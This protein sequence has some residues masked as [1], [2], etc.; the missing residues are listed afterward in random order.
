MERTV[1]RRLRMAGFGGLE[2]ALGRKAKKSQTDAMRNLSSRGAEVVWEDKDPGAPPPKP[3][4]QKKVGDYASLLI[5]LGAAGALAAFMMNRNATATTG[6]TCPT[7]R[8]PSGTVIQ[9]R[10]I[11]GECVWPDWVECLDDTDCNKGDVCSDGVCE[12]GY[13]SVHDPYS[14]YQVFNPG[15]SIR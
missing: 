14:P 4:K 3:T 9:S 10:E 15:I 13:P 11:D 1:W 8:F 7:H 12:Q 2:M 6:R 5:G